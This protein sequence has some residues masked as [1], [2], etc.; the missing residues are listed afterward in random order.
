[1]TFHL[2]NFLRW[3]VLPKKASVASGD[4]S[5]WLDEAL[6]CSSLLT[7][8]I[9]LTYVARELLY[10]TR[11]D[12]TIHS[13]TIIFPYSFNLVPIK[14]SSDV[15]LPGVFI[16]FLEYL[17]RTS[18]SELICRQGEPQLMPR[19]LVLPSTLYLQTYLH[20]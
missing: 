8:F 2:H 7:S 3:K 10:F 1:M 12:C 16:C 4:E 15:H 9:C 11:N 20:T 14:K 19:S 17:C 5:L 13:I 6:L 18:T